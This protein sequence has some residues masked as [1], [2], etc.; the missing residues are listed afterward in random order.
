MVTVCYDEVL[1][2]IAL[3]VEFDLDNDPGITCA[4]NM[5]LCPH[6]F[7]LSMCLPGRDGNIKKRDDLQR[8][9]TREPGHI[10]GAA[11][12]TLVLYSGVMISAQRSCVSI[13]KPIATWPI[14]VQFRIRISD[15]IISI[16]Y[17]YFLIFFI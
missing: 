16:C 12:P 8:Y 7:Q 11:K 9:Y 5:L 15:V 3:Q 10:C 6:A 2:E 4:E 13:D 17:D 14:R 1:L